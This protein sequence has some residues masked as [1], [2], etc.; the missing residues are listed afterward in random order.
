ME[1][2]L[3]FSN[4]G[5]LAEQFIGQHL[6]YSRPKF[7][8]PEVYYWNREKRQSNA[9]IDYLLQFN[10][11]I[12][13]VEVKSGKTGTLK[14]LHLFMELKSFKQAIRF[15]TNKPIVETVNSSLSGSDYSYDLINLPLYM[16]EQSER[17][18]N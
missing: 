3:F 9:E 6:L 13:P 14:S 4:R 16:V 15:S 18:L 12:L 8:I 10:N 7:M 17:L 5:E 2:N 11:K 1:E